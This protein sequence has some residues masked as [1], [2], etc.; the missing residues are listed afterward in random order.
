MDLEITFKPPTPN[1]WSF[2]TPGHADSL[3]QKLFGHL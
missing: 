2:L 3:S 1:L